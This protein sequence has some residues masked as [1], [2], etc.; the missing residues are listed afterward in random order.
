MDE[1]AVVGAELRDGSGETHERRVGVA[2]EARQDAEARSRADRLDLQR[3]AVGANPWAQIAE[4]GEQK[5][6]RAEIFVRGVVGYPGT[7]AP[8]SVRPRGGVRLDEAR[9]AVDRGSDAAQIGPDEVSPG[10]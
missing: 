3:E 8:A 7:G 4:M 9:R 10:R 1:Q 5:R 6:H 2:H